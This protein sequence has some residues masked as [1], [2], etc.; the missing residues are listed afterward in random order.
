MIGVRVLL[1]SAN[2][3]ISYALSSIFC[4][5]E[6]RGV[7]ISLEGDDKFIKILRVTKRVIFIYK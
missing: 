1:I 6:R 2:G 4:K 5:D 3:F 7:V